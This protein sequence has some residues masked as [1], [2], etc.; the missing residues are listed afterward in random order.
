MAFLTGGR[1]PYRGGRV[2][3]FGCGPGCLL[4][5][6]ALSVTLTVVLNLVIRLF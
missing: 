3:I 4:T 2:H 6:I 1:R 5:S